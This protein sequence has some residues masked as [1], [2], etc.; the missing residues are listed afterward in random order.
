MDMDQ[1]IESLG[2]EHVMRV[3]NSGHAQDAGHAQGFRS[4]ATAAALNGQL[5]LS[6]A[7]SV[8]AA[9]RYAVDIRAACKSP[10]RLEREWLEDGSGR[11][12]AELR[13]RGLRVPQSA[14]LQPAWL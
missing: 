8:L 12:F 4:H 11:A 13:R 5:V 10:E 3:V 7:W 1:A 2:A 6:E 9:V 14:A